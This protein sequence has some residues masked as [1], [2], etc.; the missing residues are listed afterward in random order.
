MRGRRAL[1]IYDISAQ[2]NRQR[3]ESTQVRIGAGQNRRRS[4]SAQKKN[5]PTLLYSAL[6]KKNSCAKLTVLHLMVTRYIGNVIAFFTAIMLIC[7]SLLQA[8]CQRSITIKH[9]I[10][11]IAMQ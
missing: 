5:E 11:V 8:S 1:T 3:S 7:Q 6:I 2:Q 4:K 9:C 10:I